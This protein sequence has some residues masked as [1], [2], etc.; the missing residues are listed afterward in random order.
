M[1]RVNPLTP[2]PVNFYASTEALASPATLSGRSQVGSVRTPRKLSV[3][4]SFVNYFGWLYETQE[5]SCQIVKNDAG[6]QPLA[7]L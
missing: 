4:L 6:S 2:E 1:S 7:E 5:I 3:F